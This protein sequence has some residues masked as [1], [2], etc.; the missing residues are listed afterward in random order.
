MVDSS[1]F[2]SNRVAGDKALLELSF[3]SFC[4]IIERLWLLFENVI[5]S[6]TIRHRTNR[7]LKHRTTFTMLFW[8]LEPPR[9][10]KC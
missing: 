6:A 8:S 3:F 4:R 5:G 2:T 10:S 9:L 1:A 7:S